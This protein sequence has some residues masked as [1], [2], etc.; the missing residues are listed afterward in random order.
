MSRRP[1]GRFT[2]STP[3]KPPSHSVSLNAGAKLDDTINNLKKDIKTLEKRI[4]MLAGVDPTVENTFTTP[5]E[6]LRSQY[7]PVR[8]FNDFSR[9]FFAEAG[10][11]RVEEVVNKEA[12]VLTVLYIFDSMFSSLDLRVD[13]LRRRLETNVPQPNLALAHTTNLASGS[14]ANTSTSASVPTD[15]PRIFLRQV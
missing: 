7:L 15:L 13:E 4:D 14:S 9:K 5:N 10:R 11:V 3:S 8:N 1:S 12:D 2:I 6:L